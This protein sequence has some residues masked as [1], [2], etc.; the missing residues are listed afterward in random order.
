MFKES[1]VLRSIP[2]YTYHHSSK[3]N[4]DT[5]ERPLSLSPSLLST[6]SMS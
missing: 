1:E 3:R 4:N 2:E 6:C 5:R